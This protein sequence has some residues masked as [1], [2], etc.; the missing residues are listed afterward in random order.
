MAGLGQIAFLGG[1]G[2]SG[3]VAAGMVNS[4]GMASTFG[5]LG[6]LGCALGCAELLLRGRLRLRSAEF[7]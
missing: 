4:L 7:L 1:G 2:F 6:S 5:I 3:L